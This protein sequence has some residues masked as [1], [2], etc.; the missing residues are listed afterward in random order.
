MVAY[1]V[2]C[3]STHTAA[4]TNG[5]VN[6]ADK[7]LLLQVAASFVR[8]MGVFGK[9][10]FL[11]FPFYDS[12][13]QLCSGSVVCQQRR[14][15]CDDAPTF[16]PRAPSLHCRW[17]GHWTLQRISAA[18]RTTKASRRSGGSSSLPGTSPTTATRYAFLHH[19]DPT[20]LLRCSHIHSTH[21]ALAFVVM[22]T[23]QSAQ[24]N[25]QRPRE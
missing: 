20:P 19:T 24:Q 10:F 23:T 6:Q 5:R 1:G 25:H 4:G 11:L 12:A 15:R 21:T 13:S 7:E 9:L 16:R 2:W 3:D 18:S 8:T 17:S 22:T 14:C